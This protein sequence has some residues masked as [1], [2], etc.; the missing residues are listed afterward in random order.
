MGAMAGGGV[1]LGSLW[2]EINAKVD[3]AVGELQKFGREAGK[4][5]DE[6]KTKWEGIA[7]FGSQL[8]GA[9]TAL[10]AALALPLA[11]V[12]A[13]A[14]KAAEDLNKARTSFTTMLGSADQANQMLQ[15]LQQFAATTPFEFPDLVEA[16]RRMKALGVESAQVVP[17]LKTIGDT[18]A[19][20]GGGKDVID[21]I[22]TALAQM[23][24]KGKVSAEEMNQL[25]ERGVPAWRI[26]ADQIG[27]SVPEAMKLAEKGAIKAADAIPAILAGMNEKF[28]GSMV[29]LSKTLTGQWSNFK[30]QLTLALIPIGQ[31][32]IPVLQQLLAVL[33]PVLT[34]LGDAA[35]WFGSLPGPVQ[36]VA[37]AIGALAAAIGPLL[38][39]AGSLITAFTAIAPVVAAAGGALATIGGALATAGTAIAAFV[40]AL[41][42]PV[43]AIA[44]LV[45]ALVAFGVWVYANWEPIVAV[46]SQAWDGIQ[47]IWGAAW[48][49]I[50]GAIQAVW[51]ALATAAHEILDPVVTFFTTLWDGVSSY[52]SGV[53]EI[54]KT[55][56]TTAWNAIVAAVHVVW[57]PVV[58][59]FTTLWD[60][61]S[62]YFQSIWNGVL[63]FLSGIWNAI[64]STAS[65]VWSSITGAI[66]KFLEWCGKIPGVNK[67]FNLDDAWKSAEKLG[68]ETKKTTVE[69]KKVGETAKAAAPKVKDFTAE[70]KAGTTAAKDAKTA[71]KDHADALDKLPWR[72]L[73]QPT[74]DFNAETLIHKQRMIDAEPPVVKLK[75]ATS[76]LAAANQTA[77]QSLTTLGAGL[78]ATK[79][80]A[81]EYWDAMDKLGVKSTATYN[82]LS[83]DAKT[84]YDAIVASGMATTWEKDNAFVKVMEAQ[85]AAMVANGTA[86]PA[87]FQKMLDDLKAKTENQ[88]TGLPKVT[89]KFEEFG[90]QV[91]TVITNFA[92]DI[93]KS[94]WEGDISW[95]EKGKELLKSLG[96]AVTSSFIEPATAAINTFISGAIK[97]LLG[98]DGLG[99]V[100]DSVK[101]IGKSFGDLF[102]GG[103]GGGGIPGVGGGGGG[104]AG[105]AA[106]AIAGGA[107]GWVGA[108]GGAVSAI[109]GVIG[110]FQQAKMEKTLNAIE[111]STR[112]MKIGL[113]TQ[114]DSLLND[115]HIIRNVL[116]NME[117]NFWGITVSYYQDWSM[118][119]DDMSAK[120][121]SIVSKADKLDK[122][123]DLSAPLAALVNSA[124]YAENYLLEIRDTAWNDVIR[125]DARHTEII[126]ALNRQI[127]MNVQGSDP[128]L[129]AARL[130][131][132][133]RLQGG[134]A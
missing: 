52:F 26:L 109:S 71:T 65:S 118:K 60:T 70:V 105:G 88:S 62:G 93:S 32:L 64:L 18:A 97:S 48:G 55:G 8:T 51:G 85:R 125:A 83:A 58:T 34:A 73:L 33:T 14:V 102:G 16:A 123:D 134:V 77:L 126:G 21:G 30:D 110:N 119:F 2:V 130:A 124:W 27:V 23:S 112:Y 131:Q 39:I 115:S 89:S 47:E 7:N 36:T 41:S 42:A 43:L 50:T 5:L 74:K 46:L 28:G 113:V 94:L 133:L 80:P 57:D 25:A 92:Q 10:T 75:T 17:W 56:I 19:A 86:I 116:T 59:F 132:Q 90:T 37:I 117:G 106:G 122:L 35:Q 103:G 15:Q 101:G 45:A 9:G 111:E 53:W 1:S 99:G 127:T 129:V 91:S 79:T 40:A 128:A 22:T 100:L 31:A 24:A 87:D 120:L 121:G 69:V 66:A 54:I 96:Q 114:G 68:E 76:D 12:G 84:A 38:L 67:L 6:Q 20:M 95:G 49:A 82:Q 4:V 11:G 98:G 61:V 81:T 63:T 3:E 107:M 29:E 44:A 72:T 78:S 13:A 104:G 108:I